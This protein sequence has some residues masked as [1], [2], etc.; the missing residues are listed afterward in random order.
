MQ[1]TLFTIN[2]T[3]HTLKMMKK[4]RRSLMNMNNVKVNKIALHI[5]LIKLISMCISPLRISYK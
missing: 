3:T 1:E 4:K 2:A 5:Y